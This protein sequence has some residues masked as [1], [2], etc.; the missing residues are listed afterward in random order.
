MQKKT[1]T[2]ELV[3]PAKSQQEI[4]A[5]LVSGSSRNAPGPREAWSNASVAGG[6]NNG[7]SPA[8]R[9]EAARQA[10]SSSR[11]TPAM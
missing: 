10:S 11:C 9:T 4:L 1:S 6:S 3:W 7:S 5:P 2:T 8:G